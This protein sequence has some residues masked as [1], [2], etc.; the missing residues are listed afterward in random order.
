MRTFPRLI[1]ATPGAIITV[2]LT[3]S[4]C[5]A[6]ESTTPISPVPTSILAAAQQAASQTAL[7][8][9]QSAPPQVAIEYSDAYRVRAKIHKVASFATLPLFV[10]EGFLGQ[11]LYSNPT[12]GKKSAHLAVASGIG[13]LFGVNTVTG[14]WNL[15]EARKDPNHRGR[16]LAHGLLMLGADAGFLATAATGPSSEHG[17]SSGSRSTHRALAF[18]SIGA[19]T[20]GYL[21]MLFGGH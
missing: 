13:V 6:Q 11:S 18:T 16:R 14:V 8:L 5:L 12:E 10:T 4:V 17:E 1:R 7:D 2:L 15:V 21:I 9:E 20:A 3:G 19:A